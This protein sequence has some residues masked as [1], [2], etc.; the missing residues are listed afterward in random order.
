MTS[1][2]DQESEDVDYKIIIPGILISVIIVALIGS[3][4]LD[5]F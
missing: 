1:S 4:F 3:Y 2:D 5:L